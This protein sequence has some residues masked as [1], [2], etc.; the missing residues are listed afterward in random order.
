MERKEKILWGLLVLE[1]VVFI[2]SLSEGLV[3]APFV[4]DSISKVLLV[5]LPIVLFILH[6][7]WTLPISRGIAF[8]LIAVTT[9]LIFEIIGLESGIIFGGY[10]E[11][12]LGGWTMFK[13]P[14]LVVLFWAVFI[15]SG[16]CITTSFL[17]WLGKDK[18]NKKQNNLY[19]LAP[20]ILLDGLIVVTIDLFLD[21]LFVKLGAWKWLGGGAYFDVPLGN[22]F[23]WFMVAI[24][25]TGIF[26]LFEYFKDKEVKTLNKSLFL[27]P[28]LGYGL[29]AISLA[30]LALQSQMRR[31]SIIGSLLILPIVIINIA[32]FIRRK[33][34]A[35]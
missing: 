34:R 19:L 6:A 15:Y 30:I 16:Y 8:I 31:L 5:S 32:L 33:I 9:G 2:K 7:A 35:G 3:M 13:V 1:F 11:Y 25:S 20:L 22:F 17:Y 4:L 14:L 26:R 24:I 12:Y 18:P 10:Y 27:T 21:P 28:V 29:L 23:G